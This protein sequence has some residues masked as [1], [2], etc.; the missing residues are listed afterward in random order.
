MGWLWTCALAA[1]VKQ[2]RSVRF[3]GPTASWR[4]D[5]FN[6]C[7]LDMRKQSALDGFGGYCTWM[8]GWMDGWIDRLTHL[9]CGNIYIYTHTYMC[10]CVCMCVIAFAVLASESHTCDGGWKRLTYRVDRVVFYSWWEAIVS[11]FARADRRSFMI[12]GWVKEINSSSLSVYYR[13]RLDP[14][15]ERS[16]WL[17]VGKMGRAI[18]QSEDRI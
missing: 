4:E 6:L 17:D 2:L 16:I 18:Q 9:N 10:M 14:I 7:A 11:R 12:W 13:E 5:K 3:R 1:A 8:D 15:N